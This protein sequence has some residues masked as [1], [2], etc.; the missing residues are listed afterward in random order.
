MARVFDRYKLADRRPNKE[1][2]I[3]RLMR[4]ALDLGGYEYIEQKQV[5]RFWPDLIL[6]YRGITAVIECDGPHHLTPKQ[7]VKDR[8]KDAAYIAQGMRIF[9]FTDIQ[10]HASAVGCVQQVI[11][12]L[13]QQLSGDSTND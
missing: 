2:S 10:I 5:G 9:R 8:R 3:E 1:T 7:Q 13:N 6:K 12:T 11:D 4:E